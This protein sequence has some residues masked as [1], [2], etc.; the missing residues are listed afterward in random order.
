[1][2][3]RLIVVA[4]WGVMLNSSNG[5]NVTGVLVRLAVIVR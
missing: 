4:N 1:M 2:C 5:F 3:L